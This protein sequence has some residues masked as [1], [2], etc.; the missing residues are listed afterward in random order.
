[1]KL[2]I[3][4]GVISPTLAGKCSSACSAD[5]LKSNFVNRGTTSDWFVECNTKKTPD[6]N[7]EAQSKKKDH[8][9]VICQGYKRQK[10]WEAN[11]FI[12]RRN[13]MK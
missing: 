8:W 3:A 2:F 9:N 12:I 11:K 10:K 4:A 7:N 13:G 5:I 6:A 1:M